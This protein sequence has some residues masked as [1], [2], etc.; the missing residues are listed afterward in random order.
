MVAGDIV[1][2]VGSQDVSTGETLCDKQA[3]ILLEKIQFPEPVVFSAVEPRTEAELPALLENLNKLAQEDPTFHVRIDE[4]TDQVVIGGMGELHLD[5][6]MRR[7]RE[8][9]GVH[10]NVGTPQV[11]Y[12]ETLREPVVAEERFAKQAAGRGQ[13]A[14]VILRLEPLK[15]GSGI[16]YTFAA[17]SDEIP[18]A[19][20]TAIESAVRGTLTNGPL[21]GYPLADIG[22]TVTGGSYHPVDSSELAFRAA[23]ASA[24]RTAYS[25]GVFD[26]LEPIL[27]G[28]VI[29]PGGY[30]G[31]VMEDLARRRGEIQELRSR[32]MIQILRVSIPL[33]ETFGYT[34]RL[35][36]LTQGR[37]TYSLK[38]ARYAVV[39]DG[40]R[41][42]IIKSR[43]Y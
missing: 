36:S 28:E 4:T 10:A 21:A 41:E 19:Y 34:T 24:L 37:A 11:A 25:L 3:P 32:E 14:H 29:T 12:R 8:E 18:K 27:E 17:R 30:L 16:R 43:G 9:L 2:I 39:P 6:L 33:A 7:L 38:V 13:F 23:T 31:E 22:A 42:K 15:R 5:V 1:A 26:L 40:S 20:E 35:R